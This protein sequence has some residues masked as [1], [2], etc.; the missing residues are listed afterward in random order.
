MP[1]SSRMILAPGWARPAITARPSG[2]I[3][4]M[5]KLGIAT[6]GAAVCDG[7]S[8][9]RDGAAAGEALIRGCDSGREGERARDLADQFAQ[10]RADGVTSLPGLAD[11]LN[12]GRTRSVCVAVPSTWPSALGGEPGR[13]APD[14]DEPDACHPFSQGRSLVRLE[15]TRLVLAKQI[16]LEVL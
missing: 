1:P 16:L 12:F 7:G 15:H 11:A 14:G 8:A 13:L 4:A 10:L 5:S 6:S 3:L 9:G 2:P